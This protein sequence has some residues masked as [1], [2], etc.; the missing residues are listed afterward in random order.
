MNTIEEENRL[1]ITFLGEIPVT[2]REYYTGADTNNKI[3]V[4]EN[5]YTYAGSWDL[6]MPV[7]E[8]CSDL[9]DDEHNTIGDITHALLDYEICE[10]YREVVKFITKYNKTK[11]VLFSKE[12]DMTIFIQRDHNNQIKG[13]NFICGRSSGED[14][15]LKEICPF[16]SKFFQL[17]FP[18]M[19]I[20]D[21]SDEQIVLEICG[22]YQNLMAHDMDFK[23]NT[24]DLND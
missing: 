7:I 6:L 23:N 1:I 3:L 21:K 8:R 20:N 15:E 24:F 9:S 4:S 17:T 2:K 10:T 12:Y 14:S 19:D 13:I 5:I 11:E 18:Y 16:L 22:L